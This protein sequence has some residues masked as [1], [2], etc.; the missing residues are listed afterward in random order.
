MKLLALLLLSITAVAAVE[1]SAPGPAHARLRERLLSRLA[2]TGEKSE[3]STT[4]AIKTERCKIGGLDVA[5]W[6]PFN[7]DRKPT[8]L[9]IFSHGFHGRNTQTLFLM[10]AMAKAGYLVVAPNHKDAMLSLKGLSRP[11]ISFSKFEQ[12]SDSTFQDRR[13]D[14]F[15]LV[16]ALKADPAWNAQIDW[17]K[18]AFAGHS[19]GGYTSLA[20]GGAWDSWKLPEAKAILALSPYCHPFL[21]KG[22]LDKMNV[23]I[24]FQT[25]TRDRGIASFLTCQGGAFEKASSPSYLVV[26]DKMGHF[27]WSNLNPSKSQQHLI[28]YYCI[29]FLD[30]FVKGDASARPEARLPGVTQ[31]Q[32]K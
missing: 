30:K 28:D 15:K 2:Q 13:T 5:V 25:G 27:A 24:M 18:V 4:D 8:P 3:S 23:P 6:R 11:E 19:L 9:V 21:L 26:F 12:W 16:A 10:R 22:S 20:T 17:T 7:P 14:I 32:V 29:A 1:C 31:L